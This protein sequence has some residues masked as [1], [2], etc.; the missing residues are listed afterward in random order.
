MSKQQTAV[1]WLLEQCPRIQSLAAISVIEKA[2]A[3]EKQQIM[4]AYI[5][6]MDCT[7][8]EEM[9]KIMGGEYYNNKFK[10]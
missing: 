4:D 1:E 3:M 2:K 10:K 9:R 5:D 8:K 6:R 7:D